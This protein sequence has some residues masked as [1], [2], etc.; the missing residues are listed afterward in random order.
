MYFAALW[1]IL[2]QNP[3]SFIRQMKYHL[4]VHF[5]FTNN[6]FETGHPRVINICPKG[7]IPKAVQIYCLRVSEVTVVF[8][9]RKYRLIFRFHLLQI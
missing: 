3:S 2:C 7:K 6:S 5:E 9:P 4:G 8:I 1:S